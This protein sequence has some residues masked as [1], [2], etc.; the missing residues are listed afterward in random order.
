[1]YIHK[2]NMWKWQFDELPVKNVDLQLPFRTGV[3]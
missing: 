1:M 3:T 2:Q